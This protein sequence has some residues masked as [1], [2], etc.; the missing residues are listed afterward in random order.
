MSLTSLK[1]LLVSVSS[2]KPSMRALP[3]ESAMSRVFIVNVV[4]QRQPFSD[5]HI[6]ISIWGGHHTPV[7]VVDHTLLPLAN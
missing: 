7:H 5:H 3:K 2:N 6:T 4:F 1:P